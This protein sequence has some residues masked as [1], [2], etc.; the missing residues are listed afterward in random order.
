MLSGGSPHLW[1]E[2]AKPTPFQ[3]TFR[4]AAGSHILIT[5]MVI[6]NGNESSP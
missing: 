1:L 2:G 4:L 6:V 3:P 5:V